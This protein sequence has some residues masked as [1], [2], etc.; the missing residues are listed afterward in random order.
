MQ[1]LFT[2]T[3]VGELEHALALAAS[4]HCGQ[5]DLSQRPYIIHIVRVVVALSDMSP[6]DE[7]I[8]AAALHDIVEDTEVTL[9]DLNDWGFS[10]RVIDAVECLTRKPN[11][12][13]IQ[14]YISRC[15]SNKIAKLVKL[16][17]LQDHLHYGHDEK[18]DGTP[19][20]TQKKKDLYRL[21]MMYLSYEEE[22]NASEMGG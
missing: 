12:D 1:G 19:V 15:K 7:V 20:L 5:K 16:A 6:M 11:E 8:I 9:S 14:D 18:P 4:C 2:G 17:D 3:A 22:N 13:Y 21:A 10:T